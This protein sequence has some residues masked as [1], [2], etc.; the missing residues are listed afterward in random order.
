MDFVDT[1]LLPPVE[2]EC[3]LQVGRKLLGFFEYTFSRFFT[4]WVIFHIIQII[5]NNVPYSSFFSK[6]FQKLTVGGSVWPLGVP[7][8]CG[9]K[10]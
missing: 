10:N 7:G 9:V 1:S 4:L 2:G 6:T 8:F 5:T 3:S